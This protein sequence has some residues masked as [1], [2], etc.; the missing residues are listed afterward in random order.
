MFLNII[1]GLVVGKPIGIF[2]ASWLA[3]RLGYASLPAH[4]R[5]H[6]IFDAGT[7]GGI[8]FTMLIFIAGLAFSEQQLQIAKLGIF[9]A[10]LLAGVTGF[11]FCSSNR[12]ART[13]KTV[14]IQ[15]TSLPSFY[16][17]RGI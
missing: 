12:G 15:R 7:L 4:V 14:E 13:P 5:W 2:G 6:Q 8:R 17:A 10:S 1:L 9:A 11:S 3:V 16:A